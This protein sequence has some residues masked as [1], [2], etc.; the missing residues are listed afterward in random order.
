VFTELLLSI[1][2]VVDG[3]SRRTGL[4]DANE[5]NNASSDR[6]LG[7]PDVAKNCCESPQRAGS[8]KSLFTKTKYNAKTNV[9][10]R[11][12]RSSSQR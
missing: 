6:L 1:R 10:H 11:L 5:F 9:D 7:F 2:Q 12:R 8:L 4:I 3:A